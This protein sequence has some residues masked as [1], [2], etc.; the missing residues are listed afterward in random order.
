MVV[1]GLETSCD[2]TAVALYESKRGLLGNLLV[3]QTDI[4]RIYGGVVPEIASREHT[5]YLV[6]LIRKAIF[7][8]NLK[9]TEITGIAY[10]AGPGMIGGL[11][12][13]ASLA[14]ALSFIL[15]VPS[16]GIHHMEGHLL[17]SMLENRAPNFPF[18]ALL[19]SGGHTLLVRASGIGQYLILGQTLDD[20]VG[21][22]FDKT[23]RILG[24]RYP[25]GPEISLLA[26][27]GRSGRFSFPRPMLSH[28][29][30]DFS[31][32]GLKTSV[33]KAWKKCLEIG[34]TGEQTISDIALGF[35]EA[36]TDILTS[37]SQKALESSSIKNFV[38]AGG[39]S[40][41]KRLRTSLKNMVSNIGCSIYYSRPEFC[42]DNAAMIAYTGYKRLRAGQYD[43]SIKVRSRWSLEDLTSI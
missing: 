42:T 4:H 30:L 33:L 31:F 43:T 6:P 13:G 8:S 3:S 23:A 24:L 36:V 9:I 12:V 22:A 35:E 17:S 41:N 39:V 2:E 10:T 26:R 38:V 16:L 40:A 27:K 19:I 18:I 14:H 21:E 29:G 28:P 5:K 7:S 11:I 1:L 25:G 37:K 34:D 32:S 20:A 15:K